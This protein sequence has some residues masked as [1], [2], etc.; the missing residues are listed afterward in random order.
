MSK[1]SETIKQAGIEK[2][3]SENGV[4][5]TFLAIRPPNFQMAILTIEGTAPY[6]QNKFSAKARNQIRETQVAG[7]TG[8]KGKTK[9]AK[10]FQAAYEGAMH[11]S[12][13]GWYGIPAP[14]F[15][16][17][18]ISACRTVGFKM[19][20]AKLSLFVFADGFDRD[21]ASPLVR[22]TKGQPQYLEL[23]VRNATGVVDLRARP[24]WA[25]G[26]Q[27][28][29]RIRWDADQ[30]TLDD[31]ANLLMRV[32]EQVGIGE[33]RADSKSSCGMGWGHF[34]ILEKK[35]TNE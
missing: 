32:G 7:S 28:E 25:P 5:S 8:R 9:E 33:G 27:A 26:W 18:L 14:A 24:M 2:A 6:V 20:L 3:V 21:D 23:P 10:D 29:I 30:F 11:I 4:K 16:N 19:T 15:R 34:R 35:E 31:I 12:N 1:K 17:G 22:I 13:E